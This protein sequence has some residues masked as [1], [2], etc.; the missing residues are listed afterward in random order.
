[1]LNEAGVL[2]IILCLALGTGLLAGCDDTPTNPYH[3][4]AKRV[5]PEYWQSQDLYTTAVRLMP[6]GDDQET[7]LR[8]ACE[9]MHWSKRLSRGR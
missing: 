7:R 9:M 4:L 3:Q 2:R 5:C 8:K 6:G 1:L